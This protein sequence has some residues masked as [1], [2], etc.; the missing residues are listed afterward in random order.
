MGRKYV[1]NDVDHKGH[2]IILC[3]NCDRPVVEHPIGRFCPFPP[4]A[5]PRTPKHVGHKPRPI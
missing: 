3:Y 4:V 5:N 1:Y 2:G